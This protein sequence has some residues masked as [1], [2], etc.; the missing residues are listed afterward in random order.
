[1][2]D[3]ILYVKFMGYSFAQRNTKLKNIDKEF[4]KLVFN[5]ETHENYSLINR[6]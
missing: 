3:A 6:S 5:V 4:L 1:M 2:L